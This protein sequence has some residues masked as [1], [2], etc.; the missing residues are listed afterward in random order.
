MPRMQ[1]IS[2]SKLQEGM[3][4]CARNIKSYL[5]DVQLLLDPNNPRDFSEW[6]AVMLAIF[7]FEELAKYNELNKAKEKAA[8]NKVDKV[9]MDDRLF[10]SHKYKQEL[11]RKLIDKESIR[12]I[13]KASLLP[14]F[15]GETVEIS[16]RLRLDCA[17]VDW[18]DG[19]WIHGT[20]LIPNNLREFKESIAQALLSLER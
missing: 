20:P 11:A 13:D 4:L 16:H 18:R 19:Q 6:H 14:D 3:N 7:A 10:W 15:R 1:I 5:Q 8:I 12:L 2:V 17:F 9:E